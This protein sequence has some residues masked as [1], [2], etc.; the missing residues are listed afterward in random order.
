MSEAFWKEAAAQIDNQE[1]VDSTRQIPDRSSTS[2]EFLRAHF[3]FASPY[4]CSWKHPPRSYTGALVSP[5]CSTIILI[6]YISSSQSWDLERGG[7]GWSDRFA[8][9]GL[10]PTHWLLDLRWTPHTCQ[11]HPSSLPSSPPATKAWRAADAT[12]ALC[13]AVSVILQGQH[14]IGSGKHS[15]KKHN[16]F[17]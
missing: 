7:K 9:L 2:A 8:Y 14:T 11:P 15:I 10:A 6:W 1:E 5:C 3:P 12:C 4:D 13:F 17:L 16:V